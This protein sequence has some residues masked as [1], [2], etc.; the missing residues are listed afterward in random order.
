VGKLPRRAKGAKEHEITQVFVWKLCVQ[1][2]E[3]ALLAAPDAV[4]LQLHDRLPSVANEWSQGI[5]FRI[6]T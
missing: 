1:T 3:Q 2:A 5:I 4:V 6:Y